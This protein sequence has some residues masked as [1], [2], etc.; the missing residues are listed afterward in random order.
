MINLDKFKP[1]LVHDAF[2]Q[3]QPTEQPDPTEDA[4]SGN[5]EDASMNTD[6]SDTQ[7]M[8][9]NTDSDASFEGQTR[10]L[11]DYHQQHQNL[12]PEGR[13][14]PEQR[15]TMGVTGGRDKLPNQAAGHFYT[16]AMA[17]H[18]KAQFYLGLL[19]FKGQ[20][21]PPSQRQA[22]CWLTLAQRQGVKSAELAIDLLNRD[23]SES[24]KQAAHEMAADIQVD[25]WQQQQG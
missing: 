1:T 16:A 23:M 17:G 18:A 13:A 3:H 12:A 25:I 22:L 2:D 10:W 21:V 19:F 6:T 20:G 9:V 4:P 7:G 11:Q 15:F 5:S 14:E 8:A 24:A